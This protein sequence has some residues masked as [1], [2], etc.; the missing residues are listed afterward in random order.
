MQCSVLVYLKMLAL[1][2]LS[3][4]GVSTFVDGNLGATN[5]GCLLPRG[6]SFISCGC[7]GSDRTMVKVGITDP[8][9]NFPS[10][11]FCMHCSVTYML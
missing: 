2:F 5:F 3:M 7:C 9:F 8:Y 10:F 1:D 4:F 11:G 6:P